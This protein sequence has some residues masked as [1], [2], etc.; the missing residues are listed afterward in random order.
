M[1]ARSDLDL[2]SG[3]DYY[4][5]RHVA[6]HLVHHEHHR[7]TK[8]LREIKGLDGEIKTFL[9][10]IRAEGDDLV[11]SVRAPTRLHHVGLRGESGQARGGSS[12]LHIDEDTRGFGHGRVADVFHHQ[13]E[14]RAGG[15]ALHHFGGR[16]DG[17]SGGEAR[18]GSQCAFTA[19]VVA[20]DE[21]HASE[22]SAWVSLHLSPPGPDGILVAKMA[23]SGQYMPQRSQPL[24][25]SG[26]TTWGGW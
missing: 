23:K 15:E 24:H 14:A 26:C 8:F 19:G 13:R 11:V 25:F 22:Y 3:R 18:A 9:G 10:R 7:H 12:A 4:F 16:S 1:A 21:V 5:F 17:I 2:V 20:V 6:H